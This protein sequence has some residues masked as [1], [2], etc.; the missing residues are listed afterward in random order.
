MPAGDSPVLGLK[1]ME[2]FRGGSPQAAGKLVEL[3][4]PADSGGVELMA[5]AISSKPDIIIL[6]SIVSSGQ[7]ALQS[8]RFEK[9]LEN[10]LF[11]IYHQ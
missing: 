1:L 8:L 11:L 2:K 4:Y 3:F 5:S 7:P 6:N 10:V 9:G